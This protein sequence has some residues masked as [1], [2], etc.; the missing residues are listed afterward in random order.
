MFTQRN[1]RAVLSSQKTDK[2][3]LQDSIL[4]KYRIVQHGTSTNL[5]NLQECAQNK[6]KVHESQLIHSIPESVNWGKEKPHA[7]LRTFSDTR[8]S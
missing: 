1:S 8:R 6:K 4:E 5:L 3:K 2:I 7:S